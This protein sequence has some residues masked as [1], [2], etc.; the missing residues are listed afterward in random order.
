[1]K[2]HFLFTMIGCAMLMPGVSYADPPKASA[3]ATPGQPEIARRFNAGSTADHDP[4]PKGTTQNIT[5]VRPSPRDM[6]MGRTVPGAETPGYSHSVPSGQTKSSSK[7]MLNPVSGA[8]IIG[9]PANP[10]KAAPSIAGAVNP[11]K[12]T[13]AVSGTGMKRKP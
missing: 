13:A 7:N 10:M 6:P 3:A 4:V 5:P 12:N 1:M 11:A 2:T 9:G 8:A